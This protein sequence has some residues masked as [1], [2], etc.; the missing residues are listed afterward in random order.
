MATPA[1]MVEL[2][3]QFAKQAKAGDVFALVGTLGA[4]KTHWTKGFVTQ[5]QSSANVTSPT[6]GLVNEFSDADIPVY[7]FDFYR[8]QSSDEL[9]SLG[10]DEYVEVGGILICEWA[11]LFPE[12]F[13]E[14][15]QW[16]HFQHEPDGTRTLKY[17]T[18]AKGSSDCS[19]SAEN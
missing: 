2:G 17:D 6:F 4:G 16:L 14:H 10:W 11:N 19:K 9:I 8:L 1:A 5:L 18:T 13:P 7:H 3:Q 15:T 12:V